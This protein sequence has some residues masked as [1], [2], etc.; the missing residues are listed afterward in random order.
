M[1]TQ[2]NEETT[3]IKSKLHAENK[4]YYGLSKSLKARMIS[5]NLKVIS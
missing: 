4:C 5:K 3:E 2:R 1:F